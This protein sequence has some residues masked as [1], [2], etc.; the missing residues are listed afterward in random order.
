[1]SQP[2]QASIACWDT[3]SG[4]SINED[5]CTE[6]AIALSGSARSGRTCAPLRADAY[7]LPAAPARALP[8]PPGTAVGDFG[9]SLST[10]ADPP[11]AAFAGS[12]FVCGE[13]CALG[14]ALPIVLLLTSVGDFGFRPVELCGS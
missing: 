3:R 2:S 11:E 13:S 6:G 7:F 14:V 12:G 9:G 8:A 5:M 4:L 1:M 10:S